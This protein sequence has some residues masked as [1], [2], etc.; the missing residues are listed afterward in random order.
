MYAVYD[1]S[2]MVLGEE[3]SKS[4]VGFKAPRQSKHLTIED[5]TT[6]LADASLSG[7]Y[8]TLVGFMAGEGR[9][10][11][12]SGVGCPEP[13]GRRVQPGDADGSSQIK[14]TCR[15]REAGSVGVGRS[16]E[17]LTE[18]LR[19]LARRNAASQAEK[20]V[21]EYGQ[22]QEGTLTPKEFEKW[23]LSGPVMRCQI[24]EFSLDVNIAP[25]QGTCLF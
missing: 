18:V 4:F 17:A 20:I 8:P 22:V 7:A 25:F 3:R 6:V 2:G 13:S 11:C 5:I 12:L 15:K 21:S 10:A 24:N 19:E 23:A 9:N 16:P 14:G 1:V